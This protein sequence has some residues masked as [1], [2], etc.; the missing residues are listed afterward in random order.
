[1]RT[2]Y[3]SYCPLH[4]AIRFSPFAKLKYQ[5]KTEKA[6][7]AK[8]EETSGRFHRFC[9]SVSAAHFGINPGRKNIA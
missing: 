9:F 8:A 6:K 1:M 2:D 4:Q 3:A 7:N 5:K